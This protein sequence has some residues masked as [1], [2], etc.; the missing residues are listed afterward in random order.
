MVELL[1]TEAGE[2]AFHLSGKPEFS[3]SIPVKGMLVVFLSCR[4][5]AFVVNKQLLVP[6]FIMFMCL[7]SY[8]E[9]EQHDDL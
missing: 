5:F 7:N 4:A 9:P 6:V 1:L 3:T 8:A 2:Q